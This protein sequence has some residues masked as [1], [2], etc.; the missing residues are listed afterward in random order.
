MLMFADEGVRAGYMAER[1][2]ISV[3]VPLRLEWEPCYWTMEDVAVGDEVMVPL[4]GREYVGIVSATDVMPTVPPAKIR[5]AA[6][7]ERDLPRISETEIA[8]W[9][10]VAEYYMCTVGEVYKAACPP[11]RI[12]SERRLVERRRT[13]A[14]NNARQP[15]DAKVAKRTKKVYG[16]SAG[17]MAEERT[18]EELLRE[19]EGKVRLTPAQLEAEGQILGAFARGRTALLC[20]VT[21]SGKTEI[22][23]SLAIK[24]LAKGGNVLYLVPEIALSRQLEAR[25]RAVFGDLLLVFHSGETPARKQ[26]VVSAIRDGNPKTETPDNTFADGTAKSHERYIVLGTRSAVFLP[27]HDLG[28]IVVDEE[29][30][31]SYKQDAPAPRYN[32]RDVALMIGALTG[33][34]VV[35]GSATP[36]LESLYNCMSGKYREVRLDERYYRTADADVEI[37]DTAA[38]RRKHGMR[39]SF[40]IKLTERIRACLARGE[41]VMILR[42]RRGYAPVLQCSEC[43]RILRCPHCNVP[44]T[45][46]KDSLKVRCHHCG[47]SADASPVC[48]ECG[49]GMVALGA[50]TQKV[51]EEAARLF[52][53]ARIARLDS[54]VMQSRRAEKEVIS[55]FAKG[56]T[57]IL[58]GTQV[59]TKGF[60]FGNLALVAILQTDTLLGMRDFRA[61]EKALQTLVQFRGRCGRRD[62]P[63]LLVIQTAQPDHPVYA[64]LVN[65]NGNMADG[66]AARKDGAANKC[67]YPEKGKSQNVA[68]DNTLNDNIINTLLGERK[69]FGYPPFTR[70][71]TIYVRHGVEA[72]ADSIAQKLALE[73]ADFHADGPASPPVDREAGLYVRTVSVALARDRDLARRKRELWRKVNAFESRENCPGTLTIDV[74]PI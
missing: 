26:A 33:C 54:D 18:E 56:E 14:E 37:I 25:M 12:I 55:K 15:D 48:P 24:T 4:G 16:K 28:L 68:K 70:Q 47:Y 9:R 43:G 36:S 19:A 10:Q 2:Y 57:D 49:G 50:G 65:D 31:S 72:V 39:G 22:Y 74:D 60:D 51:E 29:Q 13:S 69:E 73:L 41:Q 53:D 1:K 8:L 58:I 67:N 66:H 34:G 64:T 5:E 35:L 52:P 71:I 46:H 45:F 32:G 17:E 59:V 6:V 23:M 44:L 11:G 21:G 30:D 42:T 3:I 7:P 27:H 62:H 61:D 63:G 20:G 40:S 38:E